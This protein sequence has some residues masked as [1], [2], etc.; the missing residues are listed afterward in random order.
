MS[1]ALLPSGMTATFDE[2]R[3]AKAHA[4]IDNAFCYAHVMVPLFSGGHDSTCAVYIASLHPRFDGRVY[5]IDTG[6][7]AKATRAHVE[8]VAKQFGWKLRVYKSKSTYEDFIRER[9]FPGP[10]MHQWAY[11]RLKERCVRMI[12]RL[13]GKARVALI[14]GCRS[15]ESERRMG[16]VEPVKVGETTKRGVTNKRRIWVAPCHDWSQ[17]DQMAFMEKHDLPRN[18]I[19]ETPIAMSGE[20]FCGAF[21]RPNELAMIRQYAPDVAEEIDRLALIAI[22]CGKHSTWGT[23]PDRKK[24]IVVSKT[25]PL[26]NSCDIRALAAGIVIDQRESCERE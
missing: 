2:E 13:H 22:Q 11:V 8:D 21:A 7:G 4:V 9:G 18:P 19:K 12:M 3:I 24:G 26:C 6:I 20:C 25:G 23:R 10:G 5:H 14:T 1:D 16:N 17:A 15:Q